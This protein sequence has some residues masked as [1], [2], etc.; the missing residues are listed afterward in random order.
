LTDALVKRRSTLKNDDKSTLD[1]SEVGCFRVVGEGMRRFLPTLFCI[2]WHSLRM[3]AICNVGLVSLLPLA[4]AL[5]RCTSLESLSLARNEIIEL[6]H[7][8][9]AQLGISW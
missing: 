9:I 8:L 7:N 2:E 4:D 5:A 1:L 3:L 6:D